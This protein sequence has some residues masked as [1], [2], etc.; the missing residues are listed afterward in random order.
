MFIIDGHAFIL[1]LNIGELSY[2]YGM[3]RK[4]KARTQTDMT[5]VIWKM[6]MLVITTH[7]TTDS[8]Y[9]TDNVHLIRY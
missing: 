4:M 8:H 7:N 3:A 5:G 2:R 9:I 6:V 1:N